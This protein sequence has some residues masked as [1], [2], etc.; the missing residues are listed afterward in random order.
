MFHTLSGIDGEIINTKSEI[1]VFVVLAPGLLMPESTNPSSS[2][3]VLLLKQKIQI[4]HCWWNLS[5]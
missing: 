1:G 2:S 4:C 3:S 5:S